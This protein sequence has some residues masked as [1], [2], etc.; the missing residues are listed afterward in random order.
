MRSPV[1]VFVAL[2][3]LA[4][5]RYRADVEAICAAPS[6]SPPTSMPGT[7]TS[8]EGRALLDRLLAA[9]TSDPAAMLAAEAKRVG[10]ATCPLADAMALEEKQARYRRD[11][12][13][14][15]GYALDE[16]DRGAL[17]S[18]HG[19]RLR[20]ELSAAPLDRRAMILR[21]AAD[22]VGLAGCVSAK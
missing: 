11:I 13:L 4:C 6:S 7:T 16:V 21:Q 20:D 2:A 12:V 1:V 18:D 9:S 14:L 15:C 19:R 8:D 5:S 3:T 17:L 22:E 10:I